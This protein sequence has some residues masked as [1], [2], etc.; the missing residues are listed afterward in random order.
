[1]MMKRDVLIVGG[2]PAGMILALQLQRYGVSF[3]IIEKRRPEPSPSKALSINPASLHMLADLGIADTLVGMGKKTKVINLRYDN[4]RL[5][6]ICFKDLGCR[7][8]Y[9]LMLPQPETEAVMERRL[10]ELGHVVE[11]DCELLSLDQGLDQNHV[12]VRIRCGDTEQEERYPYVVG[13]D[14]GLSKVRS[15]LG[16][17]FEGYDYHMHFL[18]ADVRIR[19]PG[20]QEEGYYFV[21]DDGFM[22]LLPLK[23]GYHRVVLKAEGV[24]PP[25]YRPTLQEIQ[26][27]IAKYQVNDLEVYE[28]IWLSSAPFYNR[29]AP[30]FR[31][32]RVFIAGD[33][34]HMFSPIG[35]FGMNTGIGDAFNLGW[36][37]GFAKN[38]LGSEALLASYNDERHSNTQKLLQRTDRSTSL[39]A[40]L[41]RHQKRDEQ[42]FLPKME[43]RGFVKLAPWDAS[44]LTIAYGVAD[45][46]ALPYQKLECGRP[47]PYVKDTGAGSDSLT[48]IGQ[49]RY[50]LIL[51]PG[52]LSAD[53]LAVFEFAQNILQLSAGNIQPLFLVDKLCPTLPSQFC[54]QDAQQRLCHAYNL[55][56]GSFVLV[57]PDFFVACVGTVASPKSLYDYLHRMHGLPLPATLSPAE[58][59]AYHVA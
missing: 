20:N 47:L 44:G 28:P 58:F 36:K 21:Q 50:R 54:L 8:P 45:A 14:G 1:M 33:A 37:L 16:L 57:R 39:I 49:C 30:G 4:Q 26:E 5:S 43:N 59:E 10:Q 42:R 12:R 48:L 38:G 34:A 32:D 13:C 3:R 2:G 31:S 23:S 9:F 51:A 25:G 22:I 7:F 6:R 27:H 53:V 56:S 24:C 46:P 18:M 35:G 17:S 19:W 55:D 52:N 29:S 40:R 15:E 41:D 11:R